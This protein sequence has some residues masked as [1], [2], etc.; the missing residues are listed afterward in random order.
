ML[1]PGQQVPDASLCPFV[2]ELSEVGQARD[3]VSRIK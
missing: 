1:G 2:I 3:G